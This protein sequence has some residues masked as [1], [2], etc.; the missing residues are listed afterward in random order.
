MLIELQEDI[1]EECASIEEPHPVVWVD[2]IDPHRKTKLAAK[3][4]SGVSLAATGAVALSMIFVGAQIALIVVL[5]LAGVALGASVASW[6]VI[7]RRP[8][9]K[10]EYY[11]PVKPEKQSGRPPAQTTR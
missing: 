1:C 4:S 11:P 3:I 5:A 9:H 10:I 6:M 2:D 8:A 7:S